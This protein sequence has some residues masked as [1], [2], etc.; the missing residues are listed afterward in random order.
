M[1]KRREVKGSGYLLDEALSDIHVPCEALY[2]N[3][4]LC[5]EHT[6]SQHDFSQSNMDSVTPA[7]TQWGLEQVIRE[8]ERMPGCNDYGRELRLKS[9]F[10]ISVCKEGG[11]PKRNGCP[12]P[13]AQRV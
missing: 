2:Y 1:G 13:H 11:K 5:N 6:N 10:W 12:R 9:V 7:G 4:L 3:S 8:E